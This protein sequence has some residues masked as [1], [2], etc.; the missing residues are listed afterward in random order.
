MGW[1]ALTPKTASRAERCSSTGRY[2]P[3]DHLIWGEHGIMHGVMMERGQGG[4]PVY[5]LDDHFTQRN[6]K[7]YGHNGLQ[8]GM[9]FPMQ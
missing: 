9:W 4:R 3:E 7:L 2:P 5:F 1:E 8:P 6:A